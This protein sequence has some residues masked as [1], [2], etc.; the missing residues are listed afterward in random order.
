MPHEIRHCLLVLTLCYMTL[1]GFMYMVFLN[2][3]F[4]K[5][6]LMYTV[7]SAASIICTASS[8]ATKNYVGT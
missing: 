2:F 1:H 6:G 8:H 4:F 5:H 3:K 7:H